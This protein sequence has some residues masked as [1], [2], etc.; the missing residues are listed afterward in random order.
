MNQNWRIT[1]ILLLGGSFLLAVSKVPAP[2]RSHWQQGVRYRIVAELD[3]L[4]KRLNGDMQIFYQNNS[5]DTLSSI[6]L[7]VPSNAFH[8]EDN[9]AMREMKR[10]SGGS[11]DFD[12]NRGYPL[13]IQSL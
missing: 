7:Q 1:A 5:P 2:E 4:A 11:L 8:D 3:T 12:Q 9:T 6:F 10:F 13:T